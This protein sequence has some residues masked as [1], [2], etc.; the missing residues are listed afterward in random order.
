MTRL[1]R[2][3]CVVFIAAAV[4]AAGSAGDRVKVAY[5]QAPPALNLGRACFNVVDFGADPTGIQPSTTAFRAAF[6]SA[7][8]VN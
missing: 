4:I 3:A 1:A 6:Q 2:F 8:M 7:S 5:A